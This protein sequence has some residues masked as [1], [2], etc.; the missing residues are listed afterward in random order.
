[1]ILLIKYLCVIYILSKGLYNDIKF[2]KIKNKDTLPF[3]LIAIVINMFEF[4][5]L[6]IDFLY[7]LVNLIVIFAI[8][9][10]F[11]YLRFIGAGDAKLLWTIGALLGINLFLS[12]LVYSILLGAIFQL[13]LIVFSDRKFIE[14]IHYLRNTI[15][16]LLL[17][18]EPPEKINSD[19]SITFAICIFMGTV[20][21]AIIPLVPI[22]HRLRV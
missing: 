17:L 5:V 20:I 18:K 13:Y 14:V 3:I 15:I 16:G 12:V 21:S 1:M 10:L 2:G 22:I 11:Y 9:F 8:V 4:G 19:K 6:N 7:Y